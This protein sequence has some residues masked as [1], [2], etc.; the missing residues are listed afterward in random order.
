MEPI[1]KA[2]FV[3]A[4]GR[5]FAATIYLS[6]VTIT[7]RYINELGEQKDVYWLAEKI[8]SM[9]EGIPDTRLNYINMLGQPEQLVIRDAE[10]TDAIKKQ[11]RSYKFIGGLYHHTLGKTRNKVFILLGIVVAIVAGLY[12]WFMPWLGEKVAMNFS[13]E[14]EIQMGEAMYAATIKAYQ[15]DTSKT[16]VLNEFYK[17]LNYAT[18]YPISITVVAS[19][20]VNAFAIPGGHIVVNDAILEGMKTPEEL[21]ALLGHEASHVEKRHSLRALFRSMAR[22]MF[23]ALIF[24]NDS[25]ILSYIANNADALKG[26]QYSRALETE[27]DN[28]G[29]RM[30]AASNIGVDGM[31]RLMLM[32]QK[33]SGGEQ[34][35]AFMSTHPVFEDRIGNI[36]REMKKYPAGNQALSEKLRVLF[37]EI[38]E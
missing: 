18:D 38:Y 14:S 7:I 33:E 37:H 6:S 31:R 12:F 1:F 5:T 11:F 24:G 19:P 29:M 3:P 4:H 2:N 27:A 28:S 26:L 10:L 36:E 34:P 13:K 35:A 21:A 17:E 9:Q 23:I 20:D 8:Q 22:Q 30:M 32:L 15:V 25:G 16:R